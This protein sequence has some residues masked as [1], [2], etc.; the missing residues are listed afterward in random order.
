MGMGMGRGM[1][2]MTVSETPTIE[3]ITDR[4][5]DMDLSQ[6]DLAKHLAQSEGYDLAASTL[7]GYLSEWRDPDADREPADADLERLTAILDAIEEKRNQTYERCSDPDC[8]REPINPP[9]YIDGEAYCIVCG[10][11]R[12]VTGG[13]R[14]EP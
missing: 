12:G 3:A 14:S 2:V 1:R 13:V 6:R 9:D 8:G 7:S 10:Y 4:R 11:A 5:K